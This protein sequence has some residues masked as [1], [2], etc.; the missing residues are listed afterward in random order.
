[1]K[2]KTYVA[3]DMRQALRQ[4][5]E[6]QGPDAVI[7]STRAVPEGVEVA[8]AVDV[9]EAQVVA[10]QR[11]EPRREAPPAMHRTVENADF[12]TLLGRANASAATAMELASRV[13]QLPTHRTDGDARAELQASYHEERAATPASLPALPVAPQAV[14]EAGNGLVGAELRTL[15]HILEIQLA[16]LAW[17]DLTRRA[18]VQAELL[19]ELTEIGIGQELAAELVSGLPPD[20]A[21]DEAQRRALA[22]I[23][24]RIAVTGDA[25]LDRG[26]RVVFA[27][28]TGVGKTTAIAKLAARW[29]LRHGARDVAL[30]SV[31]S[32]RIGAQEHLRTL[33]R[34]LGVEAF[35]A[36]APADLPDLI[37]RLGERR[38]LLI[39]TAGTGPR[40][41]ELEQ[42][43]ASINAAAAAAQLE[44]CLVLSASAQAG[45]LEEAVTRF[46]A[47]NPAT[48]LLTKL[49]EATSLG[50]TLSVLMRSELPVSYVSEGQR[51]PEDLSPARAHQLVACAVQVAR[52]AG[53]LAGEDLLTRRFGGVAHGIA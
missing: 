46:G 45:A 28:P 48:V 29:V 47:L 10:E 35:A 41:P 52:T 49:D 11:F 44:T 32:T 23:A 19:K 12:A 27:G 31:D 15:R 4:V 36:D 50:G 14:P 24:R 18:P 8:A 7:L 5:R 53:A 42:R 6:E 25:W 30:I 40:D 51:I 16:Q 13:V 39:D 1:M 38:L 34:L 37:A 33:G 17:N 26:A 22:L 43:I 21:F 2:I 3:R 9:S 20:L